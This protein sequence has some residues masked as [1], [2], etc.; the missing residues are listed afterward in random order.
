[1]Y[2]LPVTVH[3]PYKPTDKPQVTF[4]SFFF[5]PP[6]RHFFFHL[7][8]VPNS[9]H[10]KRRMQCT[11]VNWQCQRH[12]CKVALYTSKLVWGN[13]N[14]DSGFRQN[15]YSPFKKWTR[16]LNQ[17][18]QSLFPSSLVVS[19]IWFHFLFPPL[20]LFTCQWRFFFQS[21]SLSLSP[22]TVSQWVQSA[23]KKNRHLNHQVNLVNALIEQE[24]GKVDSCSFQ[25]NFHRG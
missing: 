1:M 15:V 18:T 7:L 16:S 25:W 20:T 10:L 17:F 24:K 14:I 8:F 13:F 21:L 4:F 5:L 22:A 23:V 11:Q 9:L 12:S 19:F 2:L 3:S 6:S